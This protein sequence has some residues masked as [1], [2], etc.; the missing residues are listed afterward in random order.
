MINKLLLKIAAMGS[1]TVSS[2]RASVFLLSILLLAEAFI[3]L[4]WY[5]FGSLLLFFR[6]FTTV[7]IALYWYFSCSLLR[8]FCFLGV[9]FL[10]LYSRSCDFSLQS[11]LFLT[12]IFA[13]SRCSLFTSSLMVF[14]LFTACLFAAPDLCNGGERGLRKGYAVVRRIIYCTA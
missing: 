12:D 1:G 14:R 11:F 9:I 8:P 3:A 5:L 13:I 6:P 2:A 7:F 10:V 4:C